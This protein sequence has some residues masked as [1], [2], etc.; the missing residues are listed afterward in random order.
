MLGKAEVAEEER[1]NGTSSLAQFVF[2]GCSAGTLLMPPS[3][4]VPSEQK[5]SW[6]VPLPGKTDKAPSAL[7]SVWQ[8]GKTPG[9]SKCHS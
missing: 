5:K 7:L 4:I 8:A 2:P 1:V 3:F 6:R 9:H